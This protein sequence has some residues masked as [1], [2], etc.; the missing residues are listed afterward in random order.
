[1]KGNWIRFA[2][3]AVLILF[4]LGAWISWDAIAYL[5]ALQLEARWSKANPATKHQLES[6]LH[7]YRTRQIQPSQSMWGK[8]YTLQPNERMIQYC[9]LWT[10]GCPLDV[11][12]DDRDNI[13][14]IYT[15]YE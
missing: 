5:Y 12:Y 9:V 4:T 3:A 2:F 10:A 7:L 14:E 8:R 1:M 11:V 15:S 6:Y 13:K